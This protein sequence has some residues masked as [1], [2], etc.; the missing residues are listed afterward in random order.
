MALKKLKPTT[1]GQRFKVVS[2]FEEITTNKPEKS[3]SLSA[4]FAEFSI[5]LKIISRYS[6]KLSFT[7]FVFPSTST[8]VALSLL[9]ALITFYTESEESVEEI[10]TMTSDDADDVIEV[11]TENVEE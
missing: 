8:N 7:P 11:E 5:L 9:A 1:P 10:Y 4:P 3:S 2:T 6:F